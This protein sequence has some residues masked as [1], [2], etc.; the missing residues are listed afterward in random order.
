LQA[1]GD[2]YGS[3]QDR[4]EDVGDAGEAG[5]SRYS[6]QWV[7]ARAAEHGERN[8]MIGQDGMAE[9]DASGGREQGRG[10]AHRA[11]SP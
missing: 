3:E 5:E 6:C 11:S 10:R 8:P 1:D 4:D 2:D 7:A 9:A